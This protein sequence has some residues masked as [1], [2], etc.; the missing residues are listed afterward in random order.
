MCLLE[1]LLLLCILVPVAMC[2]SL[3]DNESKGKRGRSRITWPP[4]DKRGSRRGSSSPNMTW[5]YS[6]G[7]PLPVVPC[8]SSPYDEVTA[9]DE[10]DYHLLVDRYESTVSACA[11]T[12]R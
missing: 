3:P 8:S 4:S 12:C 9:G 5:Y 10:E 11:C 6:A 2:W 7:K 1:V